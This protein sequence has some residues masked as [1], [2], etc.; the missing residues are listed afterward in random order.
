MAT[1]KH[2][3]KDR[4]SLRGFKTKAEKNAFQKK[5][6][7][8]AKAR[9]AKAEK[10]KKSVT[11]RT[12]SAK[13]KRKSNTR[14]TMARRK[15][16]KS[17]SR[18]SKVGGFLNNPTL[19]KVMIGIGAGSLAGTVVGMVAPQFAPIAKPITA[20]AVGGPIGAISSIVADGGLGAF[21]SIFGNQPAQA[22]VSAV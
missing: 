15:S 21:G 8:L 18:R 14:Q 7:N 6:R 13:V 3:K 4:D 10:Q 16:R 17:S 19:K 11:K 9:K 2:L 1:R 22:Q 12:K 5:I 20:L